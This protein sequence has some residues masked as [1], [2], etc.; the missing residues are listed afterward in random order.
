MSPLPRP[1]VY[2]I[3]GDVGRYLRDLVSKMELAD[4]QNLKVGREIELGEGR[5][6]V[7]SPNGSRY[8]ITVDNSGVVGTTAL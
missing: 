3:S 6:V 2:G 5:V 4:R 7:R 1:E 8:E